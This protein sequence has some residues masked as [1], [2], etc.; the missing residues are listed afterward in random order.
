MSQEIFSGRR[1]V[2]STPDLTEL[3]KAESRAESRKPYG[4]ILLVILLLMVSGAIAMS[5]IS[6]G[7]VQPWTQG[8]KS[9]NGYMISNALFVLPV[10]ALLVW[11]EFNRKKF[12]P[13][14]K[15]FWIC[16]AIILSLAVALDVFLGVTFFAWPNKASYVGLYIP[17]YQ[18]GVGWTWDVIPVEEVVFYLTGIVFMLLCYI[19]AATSFV[20]AYSC[21]QSEYI[22]TAEKEERLVLFHPLPLILGILVFFVVLAYKKFGNHPYQE[23][24]PG[25]FMFLDLLVVVPSAMFYRTVGRF[26]NLQAFLI[27]TLLILMISLLWEGTLGL[28]YGWWNYRPE[29]MMGIFIKPWYGLPIEEIVTWSASAWMNVTVLEVV[30]VYLHSDR[31]AKHLL[32]GVGARR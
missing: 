5:T 4:L 19:W 21:N 3:P 18:F 12:A 32:L 7:P 25:Y 6:G 14:H 1:I 15:A 22:R 28:A 2:S 29:Q 9:P 26:I 13:Y 8:A 20:S 23:G 31:K 16:A 11:L 24:F 10:L 17:G 27:T 30:M